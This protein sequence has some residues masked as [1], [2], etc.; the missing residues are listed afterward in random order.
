M[1]KIRSRDTY[2]RLLL[3]DR[4]KLSKGQEIV[5]NSFELQSYLKPSSGLTIEEMK[6]IMKI[7]IRDVDLKCNFPNFYKDKKCIAAPLCP[8]EDSNSHIFSCNFIGSGK[9][10]S[11]PDLRYDK[12]FSDSVSDQVSIARIFFA[13]LEERRSLLPT[14]F[15]EAHDPRGS[16]KPSLG[17]KAAS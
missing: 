17:I 13:K 8:M 16:K 11:K 3:N 12:I 5:Y 15:R 2:F 9:E 4:N 7:R 14:S 10:L 1:V 6:K